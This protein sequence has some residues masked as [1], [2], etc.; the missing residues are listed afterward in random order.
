MREGGILAGGRLGYP[1]CGVGTLCL[2]L[3]VTSRPE[4]IDDRI[5]FT[6]RRACS[7]YHDVC[8]VFGIHI[9]CPG[10]EK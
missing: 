2:R 8:F 10:N 3:F 7:P 9:S 4:N 6:K 1:K 5:V